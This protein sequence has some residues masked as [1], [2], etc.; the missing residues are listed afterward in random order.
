MGGRSNEPYLRTMDIDHDKWAAQD[1]AMMQ[2]ELSSVGNMQRDCYLC[3]L[4]PDF[5]TTLKTRR[6]TSRPGNAFVLQTTAIHG[7]VEL[8]VRTKTT[9]S[10]YA[11]VRSDWLAELRT[12]SDENDD[13]K[14]RQGRGAFPHLILGMQGISAVFF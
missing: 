9:A 3:R 10:K 4:L 7:S 11:V 13:A 8:M 1:D 5:G 14:K 12:E 2:S 6:W